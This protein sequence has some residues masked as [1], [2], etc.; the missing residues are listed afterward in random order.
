MPRARRNRT[1]YLSKQ[2]IRNQR[3]WIED[4]YLY[5][6][7]DPMRPSTKKKLWFGLLFV[8]FMTLVVFFF[9]QR[10]G[11]T[12]APINTGSMMAGT[13]SSSREQDQV[14]TE[15]YSALRH[16]YT[17]Y[18]AEQLSQIKLTDFDK[19]PSR[20][21]FKKDLDTMVSEIPYPPLTTQ[22]YLESYFQN[23]NTKIEENNNNNNVIQY[24]NDMKD[25]LP[26]IIKLKIR[27]GSS[28]YHDKIKN[29]INS[30]ISVY[31]TKLL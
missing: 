15:I 13:D 11:M 8:A 12:T 1:S 16:N 21:Q 17:S 29:F 4:I 2:S 31:D 20:E 28:Q 19:F 18:L 9:V 3:G 6:R 30:N 7:P 23:L 25:Q 26:S 27:N 24:A 22:E 14:N 10:E 5:S